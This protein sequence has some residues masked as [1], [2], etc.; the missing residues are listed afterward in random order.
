MVRQSGAILAVA[1]T[2][3]FVARGTGETVSLGRAFAAIGACLALFTP[4][5]LLT[6]DAM[7]PRQRR[8]RFS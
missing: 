8:E 3:S 1:L 2:T 4:I 7:R 6:P 5:I